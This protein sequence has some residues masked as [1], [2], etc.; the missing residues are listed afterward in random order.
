MYAKD[1]IKLKAHLDRLAC[2]VLTPTEF[3]KLA[4]EVLCVPQDPI[5]EYAEQIVG[6]SIA[7]QIVAACEQRLG[8]K[9]TR[10]ED[11]TL[12]GQVDD[13]IETLLGVTI[14]L[15]NKNRRR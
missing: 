1:Y 6:D 8:C 2:A 3:L 13:V 9:L 15:E 5:D 14:G 10:D 12:M 7:K 4:A 11:C